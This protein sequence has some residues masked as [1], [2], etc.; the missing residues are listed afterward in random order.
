MAV[1]DGSNPEEKETHLFV[2]VLEGSLDQLSLEVASLAQ[3]LN[4]HLQVWG[5]NISRL[6]T[7]GS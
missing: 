1:K 2:L 5:C 6:S 3:D 7:A 4:H